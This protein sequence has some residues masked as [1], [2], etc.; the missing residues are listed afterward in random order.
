MDLQH[1]EIHRDTS[2]PQSWQFDIDFLE[3]HLMRLR[4]SGSW[5][6][7]AHLPSLERIIQAYKTHPDIQKL[8]IDCSDITAFDSGFIVW[9]IKIDNFCEQH[10]ILFDKSTLPEGAIRLFKLSK[11][12]PPRGFT[13]LE[14]DKSIF[15]NIGAATR[16]LW[17]R[18][19]DL[20]E[21]V[22]ATLFA[23]FRLIFGRAIFVKHDILR[24]IQQSGHEA[25]GIVSLAAF[26]IGVTLAII[27]ISQLKKY[28]ADVYIANIEVVGVLRELGCLMAGVVM[29]GRSASAYAA[30]IG[31]MQVHEEL[32]ALQSLAISRIDFLVMPR[33]IAMVITLPILVIY[34]NVIANVGG[35]IFSIT[36]LKISYLEYINKAREAFALGDFFIGICKA[37]I[38]GYLIAIAGC[39]RGL[40]CGRS[41]S[42]VGDAATSA[43]VLSM[44]LIVIANVIIDLMLYAVRI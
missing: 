26:L 20:L 12:V 24:F 42:E 1:Q 31:A 32:D 2:T 39:L 34:A 37:Y 21:I 38:F 22:G 29:A 8:E 17:H 9:I 44:V 23:F 3:S 33:V 27:G 7:T 16:E 14:E 43:V 28:G 13:H 11:E 4:L 18:T 6:V 19:N 36:V 41:V 15:G 30:E 25:V 5:A 35:L 10:H 40:Q